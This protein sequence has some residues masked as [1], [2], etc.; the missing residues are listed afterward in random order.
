V[1]EIGAGGEQ[2]QMGILVDS[3]SEVLYV[4]AGEI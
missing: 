4:K 3:V 2:V 1:V